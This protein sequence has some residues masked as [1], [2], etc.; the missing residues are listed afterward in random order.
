MVKV[1]YT[2]ARI[3]IQYPEFL[4]EFR[5]RCKINADWSFAVRIFPENSYSGNA[6]YKFCTPDKIFN[7][8]DIL[9]Y[10]SEAH[11]SRKSTLTFH[12][13]YLHRR[14][15]RNFLSSLLTRVCTNTRTMCTGQIS[16]GTWVVGSLVS[17]TNTCLF[18]KMKILMKNSDFFFHISAQNIDYGYPL[19]PPQRCSQFCY[20]KIGFKGVKIIQTGFRDGEYTHS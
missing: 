5:Q 3:K 14:K 20:I 15:L 4:V 2:G 19:E 6:H 1:K 17:I 16:L 11:F 9:K 18:P 13:S 7:R 12:A 10:F 8:R